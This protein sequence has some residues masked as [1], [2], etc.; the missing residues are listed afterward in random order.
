MTRVLGIDPGV[1]GGIALLCDGSI[2][3]HDIPV[4]A[5]EI[6]VDELV[7]IIRDARADIAVIERAS[8]RPGRLVHIQ[9]RR[10]LRG[11][12]GG[13]RLVRNPEPPRHASKVEASLR[14]RCRQGEGAR[15]RN[16]PMAGMPF[17]QP[18]EGPWTC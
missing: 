10:C 4:V 7:R 16:S 3:V 15:S 1:T 14:D 13:G 2:T 18:Q 17:L 5:A 8:A 9:V 11:P 6:N 12:A